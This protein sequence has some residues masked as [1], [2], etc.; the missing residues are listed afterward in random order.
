MCCFSHYYT[1]NSLPHPCNY[2]H[3]GK[4]QRPTFAHVVE[5]LSEP[6]FDL[7]N[8]SEEDSKV[9][10]QATV[11]GASLEA[12]KDLYPELQEIYKQPQS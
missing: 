5:A 11:L 10:P 4:S 9:H 1:L 8:W 6:E 2:R 7:L 3:P 12:G